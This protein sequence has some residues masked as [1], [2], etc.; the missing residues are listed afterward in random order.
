MNDSTTTA[1]YS[2]TANGYT[3]RFDENPER[4][5]AKLLEWII[6][7]SL[8]A[9]LALLLLYITFAQIAHLI[10]Q[11]IHLSRKRN[12]KPSTRSSRGSNKSHEAKTEEDNSTFI[13]LVFLFASVCAF[14]R[15]GID[16]RLIFGRENDFGCDLSLKFKILTYAVSIMAVHFTLWLRQRIFYKD[17]RLKHLSTRLVRTISW[18]MGVVLI[19]TGTLIIVSFLIG[20][21]YTGSP[22]GCVVTR[23]NIFADLRWIFVGVGTL[24]FQICFLGLFIYPLV[25]H[26]R[27][28]KLLTGDIAGNN[29][30]MELIRRVTF[31]TSIAVISGV[32]IVVIAAMLPDVESIDLLLYDIDNVV[33]IVCLLLSFSNWR[34]RMMPWRIKDEETNAK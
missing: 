22:S 34:E 18:T 20:V 7:D 9:P 8:A 5:R 3:T 1:G 2:T 23:I 13:N 27:N 6:C 29:P 28:T 15:V 11:D 25:R 19:I 26:H 24:F 12:R 10:I 21:R 30:I 17:V 14:L 32:L 4:I 31:L 33:N 16:L